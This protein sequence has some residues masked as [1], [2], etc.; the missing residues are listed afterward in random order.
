MG[1]SLGLHPVTVLLFLIFF[2]MIWGIGGALMATPIAAVVKIVLEHFP[3]TQ[4]FALLLAG[5]LATLARSDED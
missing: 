4:T 2:Q 3:P 5:D 1:R